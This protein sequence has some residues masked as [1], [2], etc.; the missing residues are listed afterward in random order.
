[1]SYIQQIQPKGFYA[2]Q[3]AD[4]NPYSIVTKYNTDTININFGLAMFIDPTSDGYQVPTVINDILLVNAINLI[5]DRNRFYSNDALGNVIIGDNTAV[6]P[7]SVAAGGV[8]GNIAVLVESNV[9]AGNPCF[10]RFAAGAGGA[11]LGSFRGDADGG[12]ASPHLRWYFISQAA[13][14]TYAK[15]RVT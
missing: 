8:L 6:P 10:I 5:I 11:I 13:A 3:I 14:G 12:T 2:G 7:G 15:V 1:M 4:S 9:F